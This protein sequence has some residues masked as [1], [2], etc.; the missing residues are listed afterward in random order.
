MYPVDPLTCAAQYKNKLYNIYFFQTS[1]KMPNKD[2]QIKSSDCDLPP[3]P[4]FPGV[5][6]RSNP[7]GSSDCQYKIQWVEKESAKWVNHMIVNPKYEGTPVHQ[8]VFCLRH[9]LRKLCVA[10]SEVRRILVD[11]EA[12]LVLNEDADI[13]TMDIDQSENNMDMDTG[14]ETQ[15]ASQDMFANSDEE[16]QEVSCAD[17]ERIILAALDLSIEEL[18]TRENTLP[19]F[20]L[21]C[22][23]YKIK[24]NSFVEE[25]LETNFKDATCNELLNSLTPIP[26]FIKNSVAFKKKVN[27]V[28][29]LEKSEI[30]MLKNINATL[31][32]LQES[33]TKESLQQ[34]KNIPSSFYDHIC[35]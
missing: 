4:K 12:N 19:D 23:R 1:S 17:K 25:Y 30:R 27:I 31:S 9:H 2:S 3:A 24:K 34:K 8:K 29:D 14:I 10:S 15:P 7:G 28:T 32:I 35:G 5:R 33:S 6:C 13:E 16:T 21:N 20:V 11:V 26:E 22:Q 18:I